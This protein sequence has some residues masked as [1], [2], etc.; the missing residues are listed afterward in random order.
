MT[1]SYFFK[2]YPV[3]VPLAVAK[4]TELGMFHTHT[5]LV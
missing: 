1:Y 4:A 2:Y 5:F 3:C